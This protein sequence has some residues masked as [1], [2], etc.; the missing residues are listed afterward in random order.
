MNPLQQLFREHLLAQAAVMRGDFAKAHFVLIAPRHNH[1]V[2]RAAALYRSFLAKPDKSQV[3]FV[4]IELEDLIEAF[5]WAGQEA[6]A[7]DLYER[8]VDW[9]RVDEVVR[10]ALK[11]DGKKWLPRL[12]KSKPVALIGKAA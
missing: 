6:H 12:P 4:E 9:R 3:P 7:L 2:Q 5:G 1:L 8:Y 10:A 11:V